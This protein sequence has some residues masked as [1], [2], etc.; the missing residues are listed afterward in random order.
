MRWMPRRVDPPAR[1]GLTPGHPLRHRALP[2]PREPHTMRVPRF[3]WPTAPGGEQN[4]PGCTIRAGAGGRRVRTGVG[5]GR[6][7][8]AVG[9]GSGR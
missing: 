2:T 3:V 7:F 8:V 1:A 4:E 9:F 5:G 6:R